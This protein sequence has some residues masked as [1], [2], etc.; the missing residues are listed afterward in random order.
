M[1][2]TVKPSWSS[3]LPLISGTV[4]YKA[5]PDR[6]CK[7]MHLDFDYCRTIVVLVIT[8]PAN[9]FYVLGAIAGCSRPEQNVTP[10]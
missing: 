3:S 10:C 8:L 4:L 9:E 1:E 2:N 7:H 5:R 6:P